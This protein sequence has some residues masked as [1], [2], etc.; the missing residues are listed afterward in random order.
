M[1]C[2]VSF[3]DMSCS[4]IRFLPRKQYNYTM[5]L[6]KIRYLHIHLLHLYMHLS[7]F[8]NFA[9]T[10]YTLFH[11]VFVL[12]CLSH[13]LFHY[14]CFWSQGLFIW[15]HFVFFLPCKN[16]LYAHNSN[17]LCGDH[18]HEQFVLCAKVQW[19]SN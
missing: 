3:H 18:Q 9:M 15:F 4:V 7:V 1:F 13:N 14:F 19:I 6:L 12:P 5:K 11:S 8:L 17:K 10:T 2:T 16:H